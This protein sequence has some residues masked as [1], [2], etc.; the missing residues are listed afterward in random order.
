MTLAI[1]VRQVNA[2]LKEAGANCELVKGTGYYW[3]DG[4]DVQ[5][6][7]STSVMVNALSQL[8]V[9]QWIEE[10]RDIKAKSDARKH[11]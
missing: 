10:W 8:S 5:L 6:A 11:Q 2:A 4:D 9:E 3:F 1:T 7:P